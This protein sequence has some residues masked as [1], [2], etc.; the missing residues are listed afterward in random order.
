MRRAPHE[1]V[2]TVLVAPAALRELELELMPLDLWVWPVATAAVYEDGP[3]AAFQIRRRMLMARRGAWDDAAGWTPVWIAFG[4]SWYDG[5]EPLPW[6]A[7][8]TLWRVLE[9]YAEHTRYRLGLG[10]IPRVDVP[11]ERSA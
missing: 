5:A 8:Q 9:R 11:H 2:A 7:H 4:E 1:N 6:A 10:G 3:R